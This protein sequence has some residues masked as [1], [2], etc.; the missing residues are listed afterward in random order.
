MWHWLTPPNR[1]TLTFRQWRILTWMHLLL[2][3]VV[4][5]IWNLPWLKAWGDEFSY[6]WY[7]IDG[8]LR[9]MLPFWLIQ[10]LVVRRW[11]ILLKAWFFGVLLILSTVGYL[12]QIPFAHLYTAL[13]TMWR[14][15]LTPTLPVLVSSLFL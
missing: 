15:Q 1:R 14:S 2:T 9:Q 3:L 6:Q 7:L 11:Q 4:F 10:W 13:E 8:L 12:I 5:N